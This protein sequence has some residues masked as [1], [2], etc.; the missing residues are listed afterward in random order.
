MCWQNPVSDGWEALNMKNIPQKV[1][2]I[3]SRTK[4][5]VMYVTIKIWLFTV[6]YDIL[7]CKLT[8]L[9]NKFVI[10]TFSEFAICIW[11]GRSISC[12]GRRVALFSII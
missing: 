7:P 2:T 11:P 5:E 10:H 9:L 4:R 3:D 8:I 12:H 1:D 6:M